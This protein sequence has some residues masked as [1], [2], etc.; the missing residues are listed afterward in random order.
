MM[1][2][3]IEAV[4]V[5]KEGGSSYYGSCCDWLK[6]FLPSREKETMVTTTRK[7][8][9]HAHECRSKSSADDDGG[10]NIMLN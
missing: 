10:N 1:E 2:R 8:H 5:W 7:P 9:S 4:Q 6:N 3:N